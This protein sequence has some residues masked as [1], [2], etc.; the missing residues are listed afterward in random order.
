MKKFNKILNVKQTRF[1]SFAWLALLPIFATVK[2][3]WELNT[4][5][6]N[7]I[8]HNPFP[9]SF[10][11]TNFPLN[12]Y[13]GVGII[14]LA[15]Y[16]AFVYV[17]AYLNIQTT[18]TIA[19]FFCILSLLSYT[20]E[21]TSHFLA[22]IFLLLSVFQTFSLYEQQKNHFRIFNA[23]FWVGIS[24]LFDVHFVIFAVFSSLFL[25]F[26]E[27]SFRQFFQ[28]WSGVILPLLFAFPALYLSNLAPDWQ[29]YILKRITNFSLPTHLN[30]LD[31]IFIVILLIFSGIQTL[32]MF[33]TLRK[34]NERNLL[35]FLFSLFILSLTVGIAFFPVSNA[36]VLFSIPPITLLYSLSK[37]QNQTMP[38]LLV[39]ITFCFF[40]LQ[41]LF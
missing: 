1:I 32:K 8:P 38:T 22:S 41:I 23:G 13:I 34:P 28:Y 7:N 20:P 2:I 5:S 30:F 4:F 6:D 9:I 40:F 15:T 29:Q 21:L 14:L 24:L 11:D 33:E 39:L 3:L 35:Y 18:Y 26:I 17:N 37:H 27:F 19:L 12:L 16:L 25:F 31:Y 36:Y 10:L